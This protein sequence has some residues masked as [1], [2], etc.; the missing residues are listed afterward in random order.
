MKKFRFKTKLT[1][2]QKRK[3]TLFIFLVMVASYLFCLFFCY[4]I[5]VFE[6][7]SWDNLFIAFFLTFFIIS[8]TLAPVLIAA[9][10]LGVQRGRAKIVHDNAA[11]I[12]VLGI[13]YYRE[14]LSELNPALVSL[15]MDL[16]IYGKKDIVATLLRMQNKKAIKFKETGEVKAQRNYTGNLDQSETELLCLI[17]NGKLNHRDSLLNWKKSRFF[18]AQRLGF[19]QHKTENAKKAARIFILGAVLCM[20]PVFI[21]WGI[22]LSHDL[23]VFDDGFGMLRATLLLLL[24]D[25]LLFI[26]WYFALRQVAYSSRDD[27]IWERTI[28]GRETAEKIAGLAKYIHEF[29]RLSEAEK[30]E[31]ALWDD[32]LIYAVVLEENEKIVKEIS[33]FYHTNLKNFN[34]F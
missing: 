9:V 13:D 23:F 31:I 30:D 11:F 6:E 8:M 10:L 32:Y 21:L 1:K 17:K 16:D 3:N 33:K 20:I 22:F 4:G 15:L 19:I 26:P 7:W 24:I 18:E 27:I 12:P 29:S 14:S 28:L 25:A 34:I 2:A 5:G